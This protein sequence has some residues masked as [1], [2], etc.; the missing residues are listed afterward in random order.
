MISRNRTPS[1]GTSTL[2]DCGTGNACDTPNND[3]ESVYRDIFHTYA[4]GI[5]LSPAKKVYLTAYYTLSDG[6]GN[7]TS[8]ALGDPTI[9]TGPNK[10]TLTGTSAAADYPQTTTRIHELAVVF[11]FKI[12]RK[13]TPRIEYRLQQYDNKD[14]QTTVMTPY[15]GCIG[16]GSVVVSPPCPNVGANVTVPFPSPFYPGT[17]VG[18]TASAR[19]LFLGADQPSYRAHVITA[20]LEYRW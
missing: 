17:V 16:A 18:D 6:T 9:T 8:R 1:S 19:Y 13:L 11:K 3:W 7:V 5:D 10:F 2:V 20:T 4:A 14:Y 15:M 12:T